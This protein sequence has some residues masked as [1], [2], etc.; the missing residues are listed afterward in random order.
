MYAN[1]YCLNTIFRCSVFFINWNNF[2]LLFFSL[3]LM[4]QVYPLGFVPIF[5][6]SQFLCRN[7]PLVGSVWFFG[8]RHRPAGLNISFCDLL[9]LF[10]LFFD[11]KLMWDVCFNCLIRCMSIGPF[12]V[13][14]FWR[15]SFKVHRPFIFVLCSTSSSSSSSFSY[16]SSASLILD[17][18]QFC[19]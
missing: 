16:S 19:W 7:Y 3:P 15:S 6:S 14:P 5:P 13:L 11:G 2:V 4:C 10:L 9:E 17:G 12:A 18:H 1:V 8:C